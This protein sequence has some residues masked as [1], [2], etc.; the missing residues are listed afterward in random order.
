MTNRSI[1]VFAKTIPTSRQSACQWMISSNRIKFLC[2]YFSLSRSSMPLASAVWLLLHFCTNFFLF[3][4]LLLF[5]PAVLKCVRHISFRKACVSVSF[6]FSALW[7]ACDGGFSV[8]LMGRRAIHIKS[9]ANH[10]GK[11]C[12]TFIV[13]A[14]HARKGYTSFWP[15][16]SNWLKFFAYTLWICCRY[17]FPIEFFLLLFC[18]CPASRWFMYSLCVWAWS[19][20][21]YGYAIVPSTSFIVLRI[22]YSLSQVRY[23]YEQHHNISHINFL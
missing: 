20:F 23:T 22:L 19:N 14:P 3:V 10:N 4:L 7:L 21:L 8:Y 6:F 11:C 5:L 18:S 1:R 16:P 13:N 9:K 2:G 15:W 12:N 17:V